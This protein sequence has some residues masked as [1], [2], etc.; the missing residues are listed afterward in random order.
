MLPD[1]LDRVRLRFAR[2]LFT[3]PNSETVP[4]THQLHFDRR[5]LGLYP[6]RQSA[7]VTA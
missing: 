1:D 6:G 7:T 5:E 4:R 2:R 3:E